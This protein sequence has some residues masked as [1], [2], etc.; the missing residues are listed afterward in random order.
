LAAGG[1]RADTF[2]QFHHPAG[3]LFVLAG[4]CHVALEL[5]ERFLRLREIQIV[6]HAQVQ[7]RGGVVR[8]RWRS[9]CW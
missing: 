5:I 3:D 7:M 1:R 8:F 9:L 6:E 4:D 2:A